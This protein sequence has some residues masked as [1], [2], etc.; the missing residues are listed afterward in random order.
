MVLSAINQHPRTCE[1][2]QSLRGRVAPKSKVNQ[3][4]LVVQVRC[5]Y[6]HPLP[7]RQHP[8]PRIMFSRFPFSEYLV[9]SLSRGLCSVGSDSCWLSRFPNTFTRPD[10]IL[11]SSRKDL[12]SQ[13]RIQGRPTSIREAHVPQWISR[14]Q[15]ANTTRA[16]TA[17]LTATASATATPS[18]T[19]LRRNFHRHFPKRVSYT[20][21]LASSSLLSVRTR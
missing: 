1:Q 21:R 9:G 5:C 12:T 20:A 18:T 17:T 14:S 15:R 3:W 10:S 13:P 11:R 6:L 4:H 2:W 7:H 19:S 16:T 8:Q